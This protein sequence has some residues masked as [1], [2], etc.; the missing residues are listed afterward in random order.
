MAL[1][2]AFRSLR[3]RIFVHVGVTALQG[4]IPEQH[5][6]SSRGPLSQMAYPCIT[7]GKFL[8]FIAILTAIP[9]SKI[10]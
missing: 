10:K 4:I 6:N 3:I 1:I 7:K 2:P 5:D 9:I 8:T